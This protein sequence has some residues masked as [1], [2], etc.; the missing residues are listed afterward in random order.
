MHYLAWENAELGALKRR[1]CGGKSEFPNEVT[2]IRRRGPEKKTVK[3]VAG[4]KVLE[5]EEDP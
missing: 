3:I 4:G 2:F 5:A 1:A